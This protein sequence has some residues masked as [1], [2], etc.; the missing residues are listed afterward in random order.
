[1]KVKKIDR[2][3]S[4]HPDFTRC[5]EFNHREFATFVE[6]RNWC[7]EQWGPSTEL[8]IW[9]KI[10]NKNPAWCWIS[11]QWR[12]RIYFAGDKEAQWYHL[13]WSTQ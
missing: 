6:I 2:R 1:M 4:G 9:Y 7:W 5:V 10:A 11:D 12:T 13:R 3:M 8:D